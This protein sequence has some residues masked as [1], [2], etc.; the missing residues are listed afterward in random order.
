MSHE[1]VRRDLGDTKGAKNGTKGATPPEDMPTEEEQLA[2][3]C[4]LSGM[5][6]DL[7]GEH[8]LVDVRA[9]GAKHPVRTGG[10]VAPRS[11]SG[12]H[13]IVLCVYTCGPDVLLVLLIALPC[14]LHPQFLLRVLDFG[15][16]EPADDALG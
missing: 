14:L 1:Q 6:R 16:G 13:I 8:P 11:P 3:T 5:R 2:T 7:A 4:Q 15:L 9:G 12:V 10:G